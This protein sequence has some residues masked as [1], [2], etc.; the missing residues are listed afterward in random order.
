GPRSSSHERPITC[1]H[2]DLCGLALFSR[3]EASPAR[4]V[5]THRFTRAEIA[6]TSQT[7]DSDHLTKADRALRS[8]L[9]LRGCFVAMSESMFWRSPSVTNEEVR[10]KTHGLV[11]WH[12]RSCVLCRA[13]RRDR[14][15][16]R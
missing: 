3:A 5:T 10:C 14:E 7:R 1:C 13:S 4:E 9:A 16:R 12:E 11:I 6:H 2:R 8:R 15:K